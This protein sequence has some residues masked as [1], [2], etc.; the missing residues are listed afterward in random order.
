MQRLGS[1]DVKVCILNARNISTWV[2]LASRTWR[3]GIEVVNNIHLTYH[4][5]PGLKMLESAALSHK[6]DSLL[7]NPNGK[8]FFNTREASKGQ[9][10]ASSIER[11]LIHGPLPSPR[12]KL[13]KVSKPWIWGQD[14]HMETLVEPKS[15]LKVPTK[16]LNKWGSLLCKEWIKFLPQGKGCGEIYA[17]VV[18]VIE[19]QSL[20]RLGDPTQG[21]ERKSTFSYSIGLRISL[22]WTL[23]RSKRPTERGTGRAWA[24][25]SE[26]KRMY[27]QGR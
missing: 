25:R 6:N 24:R 18:P 17:E 20:A 22:Q 13:I 21:L 27:I 2:L 1:I 11:G 8:K 14:V 10:E 3:Y 7:G 26:T 23:Q 12:E 9:H 15:W 5:L 19:V 16:G 4:L